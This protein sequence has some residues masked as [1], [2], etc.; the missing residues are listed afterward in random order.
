MEQL[1]P[2]A[3]AQGNEVRVATRIVRIVRTR[4]VPI[5]VTVT[6]TIRHK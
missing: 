5:R 6:T 1:S 4:P 3:V 2:Q